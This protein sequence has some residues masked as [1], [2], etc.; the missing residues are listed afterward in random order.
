MKCAPARPAAPPA[1]R[2]ARVRQAI[3]QATADPAVRKWLT[4][5]LGGEQTQQP[6]PRIGTPAARTREVPHA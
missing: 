6:A 5:I 2:V 4:A 1:S 3:R